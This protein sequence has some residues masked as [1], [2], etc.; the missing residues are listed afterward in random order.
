MNLSLSLFDDEPEPERSSSSTEKNGDSAYETPPL[1]HKTEAEANKTADSEPGPL[2]VVDHQAP[3]LDPEAVCP[4]QPD[5][6]HVLAFTAVCRAAGIEHPA[7]TPISVGTILSGDGK[8]TLPG[9]RAYDRS[10][11][12]A[13]A[14]LILRGVESDRPPLT[15]ERW[16]D[17]GEHAGDWLLCE[18]LAALEKE[19]GQVELA[20]VERIN[21]EIHARCAAGMSRGATT[22]HCGDGLEV[23]A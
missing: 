19:K 3:E 13:L 7:L 11:F 2:F 15:P 22:A 8:R 17:A 18:R 6:H 4:S 20:D 14:N 12:S 9:R 5:D 23:A 21:G 16:R 1:V 10:L